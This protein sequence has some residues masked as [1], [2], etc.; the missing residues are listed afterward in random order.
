MGDIKDEELFGD[1]SRLLYEQ[2]LLI[3][4]IEVKN[5]AQLVGRLNRM[6][7]LAL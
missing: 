4:G 1:I 3:E 7:N 6:I 5:P 2:A